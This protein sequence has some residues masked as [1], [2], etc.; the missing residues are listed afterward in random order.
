MAVDNYPPLASQPNI[1]PGWRE[2]LARWLNPQRRRVYPLAI[3]LITVLGWLVSLGMGPGLTDASGTI[4]GADFVAFYT[5]GRF[6]WQDRMGDLY[7][8]AA[9][10]AVLA[11]LVAPVVTD[12]I[13]PFINPPFS[14]LI[15]APFALGS[16]ALGLALWWAAGGALLVF[17]LHL[18][19][20]ELFPAR[21]T[22]R[23]LIWLSLLFYPTLLWITFG[24]N[25]A[26]TL[27]LYTITFVLLRRGYD[28]AAGLALGCLLY[29]PQLAIAL[30]LILLMRWRWRA[31]IGGALS[32][33]AWL[34]AG[35]LISP[36][37]MLRYAGNYAP[38]ARSAAL[39]RLQKL[40]I[41]QL[42]W[43]RRAAARRH[44]GARRRWACDCPHCWRAA[45]AGVDLATH[46]LAAH[47]PSLEFHHG[48][49]FGPG[50]LHQSPSLYLRSYVVAAAAG[51]RVELLSNGN[52]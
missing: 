29:K 49:E 34:A 40:G 28:L 22:L 31:L 39:D 37:A 16:Y 32:V 26:L 43:L 47:H 15:Y 33:T 20:V 52:G 11:D 10:A 30:A 36:A 21:P 12:K 3:F 4:I 1:S 24:Q 38:S 13:N 35:F 9:Q 48:N 41:A 25:T 44:L 17:S 42:L 27:F 2:T 14:V 19:R 7:N 50:T 45:L 5:G 18:L 23:R 8:F 46:T 6:F 51:N